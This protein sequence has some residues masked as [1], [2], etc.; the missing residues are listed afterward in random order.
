MRQEASAPAVRLG[1]VKVPASR[2]R[3]PG[4]RVMMSLRFLLAG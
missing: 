4:K 2:D 1:V 3:G